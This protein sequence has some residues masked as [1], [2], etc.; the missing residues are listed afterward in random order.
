[1][2]VNQPKLL[3][4]VEVPNY[5]IRPM[6]KE[7]IP[8]VLDLWRETGLSEGTY[9]LDTWFAHDPD[10]FYVAV[11]DDGTVLGACAGILQNKDLAFIGLYVVQS[12]YQ[13]RGIGKKIWNAV[14][15]RIGDR[16]A[17]VNPVPSQLSNYRDRSGFPVQTSWCSIESVANEVNLSQMNADVPEVDVQVL[18]LEDN[19]VLNNVICYDADI[20]GYSR[21]NLIPLLCEQKD[22]ITMVAT[23][24]EDGEVCGYGNIK[25]NIKGG[26]T[27]GPLYADSADIA[28]KIL[29][30]LIKAFPSSEKGKMIIML[31]DCNESAMKLMNR[32]GFNDGEDIARLYRKEEVPVKYDKIFSQHNLNFSVF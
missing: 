8:A 9:S 22:S 18:T 20:C 12:V 10:G 1:M 6:K 2:I 32:I 31:M 15:E 29:F 7:E 21:G 27:V 24:T 25:K 30:E 23:K 4:A 26:T 13:R 19:D 14:M 17:G 16:N 28:E 5:I 11:T 3:M